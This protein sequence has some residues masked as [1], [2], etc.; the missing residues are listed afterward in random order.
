M[1]TAA[2][3]T[4]FEEEE[5]E[6]DE[7]Y[8]PFTY[9]ISSYG[10]DYT[11]DMLVKRMQ[12]G[13]IEVPPFQ[14]G[15]VWSFLQA[16]RF[17]ESLL[18]GLPVPGIFLSKQFETQR[19]L[20]ID[21]QQRLRTL[22]FFY[23][24][25]FPPLKKTFELKG[26]QPIFEGLTYKTLKMED[27]RRLDDSILHSTIVKQDKPEEDNSS[28]FYLFERLNTGG[29][30]LSTQEI[31]SSLYQGDFNDLLKQLNEYPN[32]RK[33]Y[34]RI[35]SRMRDIELI[36]RFF[37]LRYHVGSYYRPMNMFLNKYIGKNR[38]LSRES[39]NTLS[40]VFIE[41]IDTAYN[42]IGNDVFKRGRVV[43]SS[44]FDAVSVGLSRRL[45]N[46]P[47]SNITDLKQRYHALLTNQSF[48]DAITVAT[49]DEK[50]V[51][52]RIDLATKA[53]ADLK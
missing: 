22:Q 15:Y 34:G 20:V 10:A 45:E 4:A 23:E 21:G 44:I 40:R 51:H 7:D 8:I 52:S 48:L 2:A 36:L 29:L 37:A 32:W 41:M 16:S 26:V 17:I 3:P 27:R 38:E 11:I 5:F 9:S 33:T 47:I 6:E 49:S 24:G 12:T 42:G 39:K 43:T 35:S 25:V 46:G 53:F 1:V 50:S 18:L 14:R 28:I 13:D 19:L 30:L 31:R